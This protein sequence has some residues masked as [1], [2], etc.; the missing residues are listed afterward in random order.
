MAGRFS[1]EAVLKATDRMS[2]VV[3]RLNG[4]IDRF[5]RRASRSLNRINAVNARVFSG[6][7]KT[8]LA[9]TALGAAA[10]AVAV[11]V[12]RTGAD[13][14]QAIT[15]VAAVGLQTRK[16]I[17]PLEKLALEL[18]RTTKFTATEAANAM[19]IMARAGFKNQDIL[20]GVPGVLNAAAASGLEMAEVADHVSNALKGMGLESKDATRVADVLALASARTNS[21]IGT[22][23]ESIR[24]V[25]STA[26]QL[27]VPF[28]DVTAAVALL[29]DVGLDASVAGSS[30]N[31]MLTKMAKPPEAIAKQMKKFGISFKDAEGNM[32]PFQKVI[33]QVA[34]AS[35]KAGG[36]FDQVAFLA[37]LVG[38]RGQKAAANLAE[39]F[40]TG[41]LASLTKEL[42]NAAGSAEKMAG[43]K[44]D[45][46]HG[47]ITLLGSAVDGVKTA[48][49]D[50]QG[51]PLRGMVQGMT[52]W[53]G[54]NHELIVSGF[55]G[56]IIDV[57]DNLPTIVTWLK[58]IGI[59]LGVWASFAIVVK[60]TT[61]AVGAFRVGMVTTTLVVKGFRIA[62]LLLSRETAISTGRLVGYKAAQIASVA[63]T[64]AGTLAQVGFR[65]AVAASKASVLGLTASLGAAAAAI[66]GVMLAMDQAEKLAAESE[67]LGIG[68]TISEMFKRGTFNPFKA[69]DEFQNEQAKKRAAFQEIADKSNATRA[70]QQN[71]ID[72]IDQML[73]QQAGLQRAFRGDRGPGATRQDPQV[74][75]P[76]QSLVRSVTEHTSTNKSEIVIR[77]ETGR[78]EVTK[79]PPRSSGTNLR[80][81]RSGIFGGT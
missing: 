47:D 19:E 1:I 30:L 49:F 55:Q 45:T 62:M 39:L 80:M 7:K 9:F 3:A 36:N 2:R 41:K 42:E 12:I 22:L 8:G 23:G 75:S 57:R 17:E 60:V 64:R 26:R 10:G 14:E 53:V 58:R 59:G 16:Q 35:K 72:P 50:T 68:G 4:P 6:L 27:K 21:T 76:Q 46:L 24:N 67:G 11:N 44:M 56:F 63:A 74:V 34:E 81:Q 61:V 15:N 66:G 5:T 79:S 69:I 20:A 38:L 31:T 33:Q 73:L 51:A 13:F 18:G 78:A 32:L 77:D 25:A 65:G 70:A 54:Q 43:I 37:D 71:V 29:Q 48:L 40:E 52:Q 28:E